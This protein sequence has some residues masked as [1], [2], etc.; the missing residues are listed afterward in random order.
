MIQ[1][2][3]ITVIDHNLLAHFTK[4]KPYR[5]GKVSTIDLLVQTSLYLLL[6]DLKKI[7]ILIT[8]QDTLMWRS[9]VR[10]FALI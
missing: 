9:T 3:G 6:F 10:S 2:P 4:Q 7:L 1:A 8:K 5:R